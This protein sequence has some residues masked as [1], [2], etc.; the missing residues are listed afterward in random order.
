MKKSLVVIALV[1]CVLLSGC[2]TKTD[3]PAS[4]DLPSNAVNENADVD[5]IIGA[6][7]TGAVI[8]IKEKLFVQQCNDVYLNPEDYMGK[9]IKYEGIFDVYEAVETNTTYYSVIRYGPGCCGTDANVGF[10]VQW[11]GEYPNQNDWV[12]AAG[13]LEEYDEDGQTYLRLSLSV[14]NVLPV[15]GLETVVN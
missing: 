9:T 14:L 4:S 3:N 13:V 8:E 11:D 5:T 2:G 7:K 12:E 6:A 10:E 1:L 15:R